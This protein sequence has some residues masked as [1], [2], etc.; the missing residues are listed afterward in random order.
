[1]GG[2][3]ETQRRRERRRGRRLVGWRRLGERGEE[4]SHVGGT[5]GKRRVRALSQ[6]MDHRRL[7]GMR[8]VVTKH[9]GRII[10]HNPPVSLA[11]TALL[12]PSVHADARVAVAGL[13]ISLPIVVL[14]R[15]CL[16]VAEKWFAL[17]FLCYYMSNLIWSCLEA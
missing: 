3:G 2:N 16:V 9:S 1:V 6:F 7:Q 13:A 5:A 10:A 4:C 12:G 15:A 17:R 11:C 14:H 8:V